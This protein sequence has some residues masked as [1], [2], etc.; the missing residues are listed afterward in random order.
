MAKKP[1]LTPMSSPKLPPAG[2]DRS[3]SSVRVLVVDDYEPF[4]QFVCSKLEQ[5]PDLQ[6]VS[7]AS[8]GLEAVQKAEELRPHLIVLD[9][10]LPT[11]N[12]IEAARRIRKVSPESKILFLT[13]ESSA[14]VVQEALSL[15]ALGYVV[16]AHAGS[17]LL[18]AVEAIC[19][20]RQFVSRG[21]SAHNWTTTTDAQVPDHLFCKQAVPSPAPGKVKV[22]RSH[23]V[24]FYS[25]D[26]SFLDGFTR[27]IKSALDAGDAVIVVV[28]E[29]HRNNLLQR[30]QAEGLN[31]DTA[32][33]QGRYI[34]L[35]VAETL[36]AFM[37]NDLPD[38]VRFLKVAGDLVGAAAN[39]TKGERP[40]VAACGECAPTLWAQGKPDAA[41]QLEHLWDEIAK[42]RNVDILCGYVMKSSQR[43][44]ES[45]TYERI[46]A[47]HSAV[48]TQ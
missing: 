12:G 38:P 23:T 9:I 27:F 21:L 24:Q 2:G 20:G 17:E 25:D 31:I 42:T 30:L 48:L 18:A 41:I 8:D 4:R 3:G 33:E 47:E 43:E 28:T 11:L 34:S 1:R 37:V 32:I 22:D 5:R 45:H 6:V 13:Q 7:Q 44:Q 10:G 15:G 35:D 29:S 16:K 19:K 26:G 36:S 46:C 14:D 40:R 39:G